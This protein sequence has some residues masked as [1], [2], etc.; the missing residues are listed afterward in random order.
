M[1][2]SNPPSHPTDSTQDSTTTNDTQ[3]NLASQA[4][5]LHRRAQWLLARI[6]TKLSTSPNPPAKTRRRAQNKNGNV[7]SHSP[8]E[9]I[10]GLTK[11]RALA[12]AE[13]RFLSKLVETPSTIRPAHVSCSNIPYLT[14]ILHLITTECGVTHVFRNVPYRGGRAGKKEETARVDVVADWG[15]RWIKVKASARVEG[16]VGGEDEEDEDTDDGDAGDGDS[17]DDEDARSEEETET[18]PS[19]Y[20]QVRSLIRARAQHLVHY[21][22]PT[23][24]MKFVGVGEVDERIVAALSDMG[25]VVEVV[26][27]PPD[28]DLWEGDSI[29]SVTKS[30][31]HPHILPTLNL[32]VTTLIALTTDLVHTPAIPLPAL[33]IAPLQLQ[34]HQELHTPVLPYLLALFENRKLLTTRTALRKFVDIV[35]VMAGSC[36]TK[37]AR[38]LIAPGSF[39]DDIMAELGPSGTHPPDRVTS[40]PQVEV[41]P[42][43][44][45]PRFPLPT[46]TNTRLTQ[47]H[48]AVFGTGDALRATTVTANAWVERALGQVGVGGLS[49]VVIEPR[50]LVEVRVAKYIER[51]GSK[52]EDA[53]GDADQ[54]VV[55]G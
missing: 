2:S 1:S 49:V 8:D 32:D 41:I 37:R 35:K 39:A 40:L 34:A 14:A 7:T 18:A 17:E 23:V 16:E 33:D 52:S 24:V 45:S 28:A 42:D 30:T 5:A 4:A 47:Q 9:T 29:P 13:E 53:G 15:R 50:S 3:P 36:E 46:E 25:A 11:F 26:P 21:E 51:R 31:Q 48:I 6:D 22:P 12:K 27:D 43:T 44:P 38:G 19:L 20:T 10:E 54:A 55:A